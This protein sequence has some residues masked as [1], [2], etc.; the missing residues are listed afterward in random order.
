MKEE[1]EQK[2]INLLNWLD[3]TI[4][5]TADFGAE[6]IPLFIQELLRYN[7]WMSLIWFVVGA[8]LTIALLFTGYKLIK[9]CLKIDA[10]ENIPFVI[11]LALPLSGSIVLMVNNTEWI[12]IQLAPRVYL[13]E[14][15]KDM[16]KH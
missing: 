1:L 15:V 13:L 4:K 5:T 9:Y 3:Q 14:Y 7:Y 2:S 10:N 6:Q 8:L 11:F 16:I 12:M